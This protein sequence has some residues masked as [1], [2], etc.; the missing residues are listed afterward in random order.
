[1]VTRQIH[2]PIGRLIAQWDPRLFGSAPKPNIST[3]HGL[4]G[5]ALRVDSVDAGWRLHLVGVAG[6]AL[7]RWDG[8]G[9]HWQTD[10]DDQLRVVALH[11]QPRGQP[12]TTVERI[13]YADHSADPGHNLR[14]QKIAQQDPAGR[15]DFAGFSLLGTPLGETRTFLDGLIATTSWR[16]SANGALLTQTDAAGHRQHARFDLAGQLKQSF[17]Q[18]KGDDSLQPVLQGL[19]YNAFAQIE[20]QTAGNGVVSRWTYDPADGRLTNQ[21][22]GLP[23][24]PLLQNLSYHYDRMGNILCIEDHLFKPVFFANQRV[25]GD[26]DFAY[27]SLYR[28]TSASGFEVAGATLRPGLPELVTPI[29]TGRLLNYTEQ[30]DYDLGGNLTWLCHQREGN[31]YTHHLRIDPNSNRGL[32]WQEGDPEPVFEEGFDAHGNQQMRQADQ[33]LRWNHRDQLSS[34]SLI[35]RETGV[36]D[37]ETYAYSQGVRVHKRL[38][39]QTRSVSHNRDVRY[40]PGLEIRT[41]DDSEELHVI[42]LPGSARCLHWVKGKPNGIDDNQL[43][44]SLDDHLGSST[45]ELDR[46]GAVISHELYAPFGRTCWWAARSAVEADYKTTR[47]SGKE[48]DVSGLYYYGQRYYAPWLQRWVSADP[49]GDVD[50]LNLYAMV[51]NN[52]VRYIDKEGEIKVVFDILR[53]SIGMLDTAKNAVDQMHNLATKFDAL[54]PEGADIAQVRESMTFGKFIKSRHGI[55]SVVKGMAEGAAAGAAI[56]SVVPGIGSAIGAGVGLVVGAIAM[57]AL[58]YYFFKKGLKLAEVL[59]TEELKNVVQTGSDIANQVSDGLQS[60]VN[61]GSELLNKIKNFTDSINAYP[62]RIQEMFYT[63]LEAL[64]SD[65]Q[66]EVMQL[67]NTGID[68]FEAIDKVLTLAQTAVDAASEA[69]GVT[70]RLTQLEQEVAASTSLPPI[71][72]PRTRLPQNHKK[73]DGSVA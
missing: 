12:Q 26:R 5:T 41:L 38:I 13:T 31:C 36:N 49:G 70:E 42:T 66:R 11:E 58:R 28:Q 24:Q 52:P 71:P 29:D 35:E 43:R 62:E 56:G 47:Y 30:Y 57:P 22:A 19:T 1:M 15:L 39:T 72:Q 23:G 69:E 50:G 60:A 45:L 44:Y 21:R 10:Y 2:D 4:S 68:P 18:L 9:C 7:Q 63:Q 65:K 73:V 55:K 67:L 51:G 48:M 3:V 46:D 61:G 33:P 27:D 34:A 40:L 17:L 59:H 25:D 53:H 64:A 6:Q 14:G 16:Y 54:V 8:R 37:E 32:S 20:T